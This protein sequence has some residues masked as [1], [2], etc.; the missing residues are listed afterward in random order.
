[1]WGRLRKTDQHAGQQSDQPTLS[2]A[3]VGQADVGQADVGQ[4]DV[5]QAEQHSS[6]SPYQDGNSAGGHSGCV[7]TQRVQ[8]QRVQTHGVHPVTDHTSEN[9]FSGMTFQNPKS[10]VAE[11]APL[12]RSGSRR[13]RDSALSLENLEPRLPLDGSAILGT[14]WQDTDQDAELD[15]DESP[16]AGQEVFLAEEQTFRSGTLYQEDFDDG[17]G[18]FQAPL[19]EFNPWGLTNTRGVT[20]ND[21]A[22][23]FGDE[24][25]G[26]YEN[27]SQ[28]TLRSSVIDLS[29]ATPGEDITLT[30]R[31]FLEAEEGPGFAFDQAIVSVLSG[32]E[33]TVLADNN[34]GGG[35]IN[36]STDQFDQISLDLSDFAGDQ[37]QLSFTFIS[38]QIGT[39]EGWYLDDFVIKGE[40]PE[41]FF[42]ADF[43]GEQ[44]NGFTTNQWH[45]SNGNGADLTDF[46]YYFGAGE[47]PLVG[48]GQYDLSSAGDLISPVIDLT[49]VTGPVTLQFDQFLS[50]EVDPFFQIVDLAT[51]SVR[52]PDGS[53]FLLADNDRFFGLGNLTNGS[54][55]VNLQLDDYTGEKIQ[56]VF[57]FQSDPFVNDEGWYIDDISIFTSPTNPGELTVSGI[58]SEVLDLNVHLQLDQPLPAGAQIALVGPD[59][60]PVQLVADTPPGSTLIS[61]TFDDQAAAVLP[62]NGGGPSGTFQPA[63]PL[64][65]LL[66]GQING[67]W[68]LEFTDSN[69]NPLPLANSSVQWS[70]DVLA[71][72]PES[73]LTDSQGNFAFV[74]LNEGEYVVLTDATGSLPPTDLPTQ[75]PNELGRVN[76]TQP[77]LGSPPTLDQGLAVIPGA[78]LTGVVFIDADANGQLD[79]GEPVLEG[80]TVFLDENGNG[81]HDSGERT[82]TT[83]PRGR[84]FFAGLIPGTTYTI[85]DPQGTDST[86]SGITVTLGEREVTEVNLANRVPLGTISG[87]KFFDLDG[88]GQRQADE[89]GMAGW[90]V[91]LDTNG[92]GRL[93]SQIRHFAS[94]EGL[95]EIEETHDSTIEVFGLTDPIEEVVVSI[96]LDHNWNEDLEVFLVSP[97]GTEVELFTDVGG[98]GQGFRGVV[99]DDD[100][101]ELVADA[102]GSVSGV[103]RPEGLLSAFRGENANGTWTLKVANDSEFESGTLFGW[104]LTVT[105]RGAGLEPVTITD[106][107]GNFS[108]N[109]LQAGN[110]RVGEVLR[111]S[112]EQTV[113]AGD[114]FHNVTITGGETVS[115]LL[116]GNAFADDVANST[117]TR[118]PILNPASEAVEQALEDR[119]DLDVFE[120]R[121]GSTGLVTVDV[122]PGKEI[123]LEDF[124]GRDDGG[125]ELATNPW[126]LSTGRQDSLDDFAWY[127]G[128]NET[129]LQDDGQYLNNAFGSLI[130]PVIDLTHAQGD[131]IVEFEQFLGAEVAFDGFALD[132]AT[133][134]VLLADG[135]T[136]LLADNQNVFGLGG[137]TNGSSQVSLNLDPAYIGQK[138]QLVFTFDSDII[139]VDEGWYLDEFLVKDGNGPLFSANFDG[140]QTE[141]FEVQELVNPWSLSNIPSDDPTNTAWNF[142][143]G[144][145]PGQAGTLLTPG[146]DLSEISGKISLQFDQILQA[147]RFDYASVSVIV[148]GESIALAD[149]DPDFGLGGLGGG[150]GIPGP[151]DPEGF[152]P[153]Q[154]DLSAFAGQEIQLE[155]FFESGPFIKTDRGWSIDNVSIS[156]D[157]ALNPRTQ[158]F[159]SSGELIATNDDVL[160]G[161]LGSRVQ[162][163]ATAG[164][165]FSVVV[166]S[167]VN[168][169]GVPVSAGGYTLETSEDPFVPADD[170]TN[171]FSGADARP[172]IELDFRNQATQVGRI[173]FAG[174]LDTY[175]FEVPEN[176]D[177][178]GLDD[179]D[180]TVA[181]VLTQEF[182]DPGDAGTLE[183]FSQD[184]L[185]E[186]LGSMESVEGT[187]AFL[188]LEV[189]R[190]QT[191]Y[192]RSSARDGI[193]PNPENP[194]LYVPDRYILTVQ[195]IDQEVGDTPGQS[196]FLASIETTPGG[197]N[198]VEEFSANSAIDFVN[199]ADYFEFTSPITGTFTIQVLA[200]SSVNSGLNPVIRLLDADRQ[201]I[202]QNDDAFLTGELDSASEWE[203]TN[204]LLTV[205][206]E[207]GQT[208]FLEVTGVEN[209]V[210]AYSLRGF[211]L[212]NDVA[213][214]PTA[215]TTLN[216]DPA[217]GGAQTG[218]IEIAEDF[219][220]FRLD[221][222][223]SVVVVEVAPTEGSAVDPFLAVYQQT[224]SGLKLVDQDDNQGG[225][226]TSSIVLPPGDN[227]LLQVGAAGATQG[228]YQITVSSYVND[229]GTSR[230]D[231]TDITTLVQDGSGVISGTLAITDEEDWL[232]FTVPEG[233]VLSVV[234]SQPQGR[235]AV[236]DGLFGPP[237]IDQLGAISFNFVGGQTY[238][239]KT[240]IF[241]QTGPYELTFAAQANVNPGQDTTGDD[242]ALSQSLG[243]VNTAASASGAIDAA[244]DQD[245]YSFTAGQSGLLRIQQL[246]GGSGLDPYV[247]V[248][249]SDELLVEANDDSTAGL[250]SELFFQVVAGEQ[251]FIQAG[252]FESSTGSYTLLLAYDAG[253]ADSVGNDFA[254]A[255]LIEAPDDGPP[256]VVQTETIGTPGD[257][258]FYQFTAKSTGLLIVEVVANG[259]DGFLDPFVYAYDTNE[260]QL[261]A[262]DD[263]GMGLNSL[264]EIDVVEGQT[265][266]IEVDAFGA[267]TGSYDLVLEF[268]GDRP[269]EYGN[270]FENASQFFQP[271]PGDTNEENEVLKEAFANG[272][273]PYHLVSGTIWSPIDDL[274]DTDILRFTAPFTGPVSV[275]VLPVAGLQPE[276]F[277]HQQMPDGVRKL[278]EV[279]DASGEIQNIANSRPGEVREAVFELEEGE[280]YFLKVRGSGDSFGQYDLLMVPVQDDFGI[281]TDQARTVRFTPEQETSQP[282]VSQQETFVSTIQGAVD[283]AEDRD[284]VQ[285]TLP[286]GNFPEGRSV[287]TITQTNPP[288]SNLDAV[289]VL[290]DADGTVLATA[291]ATARGGEV[292]EAD[293]VPERTYI[294]ETSG[295]G[296]SIG[297]YQLEIQVAAPTPDVGDTVATAELLSFPLP[298]TFTS[299]SASDDGDNAEPLSFSLPE[300]LT[301]DFDSADDVDIFRFIAPASGRVTLNWSAQTGSDATGLL[302]IFQE[303][304]TEV[305]Q[306]AS[307]D[308][309]RASNRQ[310]TFSITE[311]TTYFVEVAS[312]GGQGG[313]LVDI[314]FTPQTSTKDGFIDSEVGVAATDHITRVLTEQIAQLQFADGEAL[315]D[316]IAQEYLNALQAVGEVVETPTL[317]LVVDPVDFVAI[318]PNGAEFGRTQDRGE[319]NETNAFYSGDGYLEVAI[320]QNAADLYSVNLVG[321]GDTNVLA[322]ARLLLPDSNTPVTPQIGLPSGQSSAD[323]LALAKGTVTV[324]FDFRDSV[325]T[326]QPTTTI[327]TFSTFLGPSVLASV[328]SS[329]LLTGPLTF[330]FDV[331]TDSGADGS[332]S[333]TP[334]WFDAIV[335]AVV[336]RVLETEW[337]LQNVARQSLAALNVEL[338]TEQEEAAFNFAFDLFGAFFPQTVVA[339]TVLEATRQELLRAAGLATAYPSSYSAESAEAGGEIQRQLDDLFVDP[340]DEQEQA[341]DTSLDPEADGESR[342]PFALPTPTPAPVP[343]AS[344]PPAVQPPVSRPPVYR[345]PVLPPVYP[346]RPYVPYAPPPCRHHIILPGVIHRFGHYDQRPEGQPEEQVEVAGLTA[347]PN[348]ADWAS[349]PIAGLAGAGM[350]G[351]WIALSR[352]R[353][354]SAQQHSASQQVLWLEG[355]DGKQTR[356]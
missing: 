255:Q 27:D 168:P 201:E 45:R 292:L 300:T 91:Y 55:T 8:T 111:P 126:H 305:V 296:T 264:L 196:E 344:R 117:R 60:T 333:S 244:G 24:Q 259:S 108:F 335:R 174:E 159:N 10:V 1:M 23:Y 194:D 162:F 75:L 214:D 189:E 40:S 114:G 185:T 92:N 146:I 216:L 265:Y 278:L 2:H 260:T 134:E 285:F 65:G 324:V 50:A 98:R 355:S 93:D 311:G 123:F 148:E 105:T 315:A 82:T 304:D 56:L 219:D 106:A 250:D 321:V 331:D 282:G 356:G 179:L 66:A 269:D 336:S 232:Q 53:T 329:V 142:G 150:F 152:S 19:D 287:V 316:E 99:L 163:E 7:Q 119:Y 102:S 181:L 49:D 88:N 128:G 138:I 339:E 158:I 306:I 182:L 9:H 301:S 326:D 15:R 46:G 293:L 284:L 89:P 272:T 273:R 127:F 47:Q 332:S 289:L 348:D 87:T 221:P 22:F 104:A 74:G 137:L 239:L 164:E 161:D 79:F 212:T 170:V 136:E 171:T 230:A 199:D 234:H 160:P 281:L 84:Y 291:D 3:D 328:F 227:Y 334:G 42:S 39:R 112:W 83:G 288:G 177:I 280:V 279:G 34:P 209:N 283:F 31:Y 156:T 202:A 90:L 172:A 52:R 251:Y 103:F 275:A 249:N 243:V 180:S 295:F 183:V 298:E 54:S 235:L 200:D 277:I 252:A 240:E 166:S 118:P 26:G 121:A 337:T 64:A 270:T 16:L 228:D 206:L 302:Q 245:F 352:L 165:R 276:L 113:P 124:G 100:A 85:I 320:V 116:L 195:L 12:P 303:V 261:A 176:S 154:L 325:P 286:G 76:L 310:A 131:V 63:E 129:P 135:S 169:Q 263:G 247:F 32:G 218:S 246:S 132:E 14:L 354:R 342:E 242:F 133:V 213:N 139:G 290:S 62:A 96:D 349:Y 347:G 86:G 220:V 237:L 157:A 95:V 4:A 25:T 28:G 307:D 38:D 153:I 173:N 204:S 143:D 343:P 224:N 36:T 11:T 191:Y 257:Q 207:A 43:D 208:Y 81:Q 299:T 61:V 109:N 120:Y 73:T 6:S 210:G 5:G 155:F 20:G 58:T 205:S 190:G 130:S 203:S 72:R 145:S 353:S 198:A 233:G 193:S 144:G 317:L 253:I 57:S 211:A 197:G 122:A 351:T 67:I 68:K 217:S 338:G 238:F 37:I 229:A 226:N 30:F 107:Q 341:G 186:P 71:R 223:N 141:G 33:T 77:A 294:L 140:G 110:Y 51:V 115:G 188:V 271:L 192:L 59:N 323:Q 258:D 13:E 248:Y 322:N 225:G 78:G 101:E 17:D 262:D 21:Y 297:D 215:A 178:E 18:G 175:R 222:Q 330:S 350:L 97:D 149:N 309:G 274:T 29:S 187:P 35:L 268:D 94:E 48:G 256:V 313:Y 314:Q 80:R 44:T 151:G 318:D 308:D 346:V 266:F 41:E 254:S 231:A 69:G 312:A 70:L 236:Y 125:F 267:S 241:G 319:I 147:D 345:T 167:A 327:G 340:A 184:N